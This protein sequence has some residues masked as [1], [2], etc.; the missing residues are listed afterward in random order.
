M[1]SASEDTA[2][3]VASMGIPEK[4]SLIDVQRQYLAEHP[5]DCQA[6]LDL[7]RRLRDMGQLDQAA[8]Q[9]QACIEGGYEVLPAVM[10]DLELLARLYP[11]TQSI[12][13]ALRNA[14]E[15]ERRVPPASQ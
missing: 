13:D 5:D 2:D 8:A 1:N 15:R 14:S 6:R 12:D 3:E 9:Y 11:G 10:R 4:M 7:A